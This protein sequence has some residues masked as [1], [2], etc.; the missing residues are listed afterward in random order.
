MWGRGGWGPAILV[1]MSL[2][3]SSS[4]SLSLS[5]PHGG[6]SPSR[7]PPPCCCCSWCPRLSCGMAWSSS[8]PLFCGCLRSRTPLHSV[9]SRSEQQWWVL[10][11]AS[12]P[13]SLGPHQHHP[14]HHWS[15]PGHCHCH[16]LPLHCWCWH[17]PVL[18]CF[19]FVG[20]AP[21]PFCHCGLSLSSLC[22]LLVSTPWAAACSGGVLVAIVVIFA[23]PSIPVPVV[24]FCRWLDPL[25]ILQAGA[26]SGGVCV[27]VLSGYHF[28]VNNIDRT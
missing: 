28:M 22:N 10:G 16:H 27:R 9:S 25:S 14:P 17:C 7:S 21:L 4:S 8:S 18:S 26:R 13:A 12:H 11:H 1:C 19:F 2:S 3:A 23:S 5:P 20:M 15:S 6:S 24:L